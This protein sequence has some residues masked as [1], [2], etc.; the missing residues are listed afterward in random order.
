MSDQRELK[1][2]EFPPVFVG[3]AKSHL[4]LN[5]QNLRVEVNHLRRIGLGAAAKLTLS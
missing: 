2:A 5:H 3:D 1:V 4:F